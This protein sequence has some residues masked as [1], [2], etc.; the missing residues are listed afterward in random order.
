MVCG[1]GGYASHELARFCYRHCRHATLVNRFRGDARLYAAA[2]QRRK[3]TGRPRLKGRKLPTPQQVVDRQALTPATVSWYGGGDR[4]VQRAT[5][6]GL[7]YKTGAG[8]VPIRWVFVRDV[9]GTH[10]D[11]YFY[12][13]DPALTGPQIVRWFTARWSIET[14]FQEIRAHLGLE[15]TRQHVAQ[16]V[17]RTAP[18][19]LGLFRVICLIYAEHVQCHPLGVRQT[20]WYVKDEPTFSDAM[21]TVRRLFWRELLFRQPSDRHGFQKLPLKI[22]TWM[23]DRLCQA[24]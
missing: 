19:L 12:T 9:Q 16:S 10:R 14:T 3:R 1:D 7:W 20:R 23:L 22:R 15:T 24:A 11:E 4:R 2:P 5:G 13:T 18:C 21:A 17:R 6:T 8:V